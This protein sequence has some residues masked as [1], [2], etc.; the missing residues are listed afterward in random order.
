[1]MVST[2][3]LD[4]LIKH[5]KGLG[6]VGGGGGASAVRAGQT[7]PAASDTSGA[8]LKKHGYPPDSKAEA[9]KTFLVQADLLF[10][11]WMQGGSGLDSARPD[12]SPFCPYQGLP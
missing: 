11:Q 2:G 5:E 10:A 12:A 1:M 9:V 6:Q 8:D 7:E 4:T 3:R